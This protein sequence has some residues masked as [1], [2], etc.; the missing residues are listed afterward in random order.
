MWWWCAG[1]HCSRTGTCHPSLCPRQLLRNFQIAPCPGQLGPALRPRV[2]SC[3]TSRRARTDVR[4]TW[5]LSCRVMVSPPEHV[6][7]PV[8]STVLCGTPGG[9]VSG[10]SGS[11]S[12][13]HDVRMSLSHDVLMGSAREPSPGQT[14]PHSTTSAQ[15]WCHQPGQ[16]TQTHDIRHQ[17]V[18]V[19]NS[20]A[21]TSASF[22]L[23][24][25]VYG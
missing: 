23:L 9:M 20:S 1:L 11:W 18:N 22:I 24:H 8:S 19:W 7:V 25:N 5:G 17:T 21:E 4:N 12:R 3:G 2:R 16:D 6:A 13:C 15:P 10:I 14:T